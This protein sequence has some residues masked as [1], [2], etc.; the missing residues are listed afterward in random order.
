MMRFLRSF[1]LTLKEWFL[2]PET[3]VGAIVEANETLSRF[4]FTTRHFRRQPLR[5]KAEAYMPR[6]GQVSVFRVDGLIAAQIW[7]IGDEIAETRD[8]T[9]YA[10]GDIKAREVGRSGLDIVPA[11]PPPRH[12]NIVG[13]PE[14]DKP[15]QKLIALQLAAVATLVLKE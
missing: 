7:E 4:I 9:L 14:N 6:E 3:H 15:R 13:W 8:R 12:A 5:V 1:F 2:K 10:R 11:Q